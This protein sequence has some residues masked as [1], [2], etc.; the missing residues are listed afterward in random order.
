[1][2]YYWRRKEKEKMKG[3]L[4]LLGVIISALLVNSTLAYP[5][6]YT[7]TTSGTGFAQ[8]GEWFISHSGY[9]SVKMGTVLGTDTGNIDF[10]GDGT[11]GTITN[12]SY[13]VYSV[14]AG[15]FNQ[16]T[17]WIA[18]YLTNDPANIKTL[19]D[20]K[21]AYTI[22][23]A[24][25]RLFFIQAEPYYAYVD[26]FGGIDITPIMN[27][28]YKVD[29]FDPVAPLEWESLEE[30]G[31]PHGAPTLAQYIAGPVPT[32][33]SIAY[34]GLTICSI[35]IRMGY[36]GPWVNTLAYVDDVK[37]NDY[38]E[39]FD[40]PVGGKWSPISNLAF[41][42][43][44]FNIATVAIVAAAVAALAAGSWRLIRKRW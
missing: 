31:G 19:T 30:T 40:P 10:N 4:I 41:S 21:N 27:H 34:G 39:T 29:A 12:L 36:G 35:R 43:L 33:S 24:D 15:T 11:L 16:L 13:W 20:W 25:P 9:N 37:I 5:S 1:M 18:I 32:Y 8:K 23:P 42:S 44:P 6:G 14:Q 7:L 17:A 3:K 26:H 38:L 2:H 22:N 28:W